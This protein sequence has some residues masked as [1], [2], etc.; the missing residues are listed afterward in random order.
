MKKYKISLFWPYYDGSKVIES[1]KEVFPEDG[2]NKWLAEADRVKEFE[3]VFEKKLRRKNAVALNSGTAGLVLAFRLAGVGVGDEVIM[4][5]LNCSADLHALMQLGGKP[6]L[7]DVDDTLNIDV[8]DIEHRITNKTKAILCV[9]F[10]GYPCEIEEVL[11]IARKHDL[12]VIED[13]CQY[14]IPR[15]LLADYEVFSFQAIKT[16]TTGD[17]GLLCCNDDKDYER[18]RLLRWFD[19]DRDFKAKQGY[20]VFRDWEMRE[21]LGGPQ[22]EVGYKFQMSDVTAAIGLAQMEDLDFVIEKRR[23]LTFLYRRELQSVDGLRILPPHPLEAYWLFHIFTLRRREVAEALEDAGVEVNVVHNRNDILPLVGA[24]RRL[25]L[26]GMNRL[27]QQ[28]LCLPLHP[29][30]KE[31]D[32]IYICSIIKK[33]LK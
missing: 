6:V 27:E 23:R 30:L 25:D 33:V 3:K 10:G 21:F 13:S 7:C 31:E 32:V 20:K 11:S 8:D 18:A 26:C 16:L 19:I 28:Y 12:K 1:L 22:S 5:V 4:P 15:E 14:L 29:R 24:S 2:S 17:G 9:N